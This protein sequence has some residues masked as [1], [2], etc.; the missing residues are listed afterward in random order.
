MKTKHILCVA[1][2]LACLFYAGQASADDAT[3]ESGLFTFVAPDAM[4]VLDLSG[5]MQ[6]NP[7]GDHDA[8]NNGTNLYSDPTCAGPFYS[9]TNHPGYT[10]VCSRY[11]I[12]RRTNFN[13]LDDNRDGTINSDDETSLNIRFGLGKFQ[14]STYTKLRNIGTKYSQ[15]YC[16]KSD[17]C[18]MDGTWNSSDSYSIRYW[19]QDSRVSGATPL[20]TALSSVKT[21]L[22]A[23]KA[24]DTY[25]SCR[26]KFVI[27]ISDG[28]DT[29]CCDGSGSDTQSDQY[30]RRRESVLAAK[31]LADA[32]YKVFVIGMGSNMPD[33]LKNTLNWMA[34]YGGTDNP[35]VPN[36]GLTSGFDPAAVSSCG[37]SSTTG[38]CNGTS[39]QCFATSNDPGTASLSGYAFL[40]N[41]SAELEAALQQ[42]ISYIREATY[43]FTQASVA[44]SRLIDENFL[45]LY[46]TKH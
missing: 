14:G 21:Y 27:L 2:A 38:T 31:A 16:G 42:A 11:K 33:Y 23:N 29:M 8:F 41:N 20:A 9:N 24:A 39:D 28:A 1:A 40:A 4:I 37:S 17:S 32:G 34:Y 5:S 18:T 36:S 10:T 7:P 26:Q 12:A 25:K 30:K 22:D 43:S 35:L 13:I 46:V 45:Y 44:S 19:A 6:W 15:I 3:D